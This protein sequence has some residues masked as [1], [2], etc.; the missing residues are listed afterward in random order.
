MKTMKKV[1]LLVMIASSLAAVS[2]AS[3]AESDPGRIVYAPADA[4]DLVAAKVKV[5]IDAVAGGAEAAKAS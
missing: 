5:A 3:F 1:L 2:T 4:I